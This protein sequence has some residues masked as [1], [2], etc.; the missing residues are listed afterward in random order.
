LASL[1]LSAARVSVIVT[2]IKEGYGGRV[3]QSVPRAQR[4]KVIAALHSSFAGSLNDLLILSGA[5]ALVGAFSALIL[6][7]PKDFVSTSAPVHVG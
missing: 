1:N 2:D 6:I 5:M 3:I 7:R 4:A